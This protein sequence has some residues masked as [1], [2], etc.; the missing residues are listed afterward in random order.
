VP[1]SFFETSNL[2]IVRDNQAEFDILLVKKSEDLFEAIYMKCSHRENPLTATETGLYCS[3]HGSIF[4]LDGNVKKEPAT[5]PLQKFPVDFD[6]TQ[7]LVSINIQSL[8][9]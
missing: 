4:D 7:G 8:K 6:R 1:V 3:A 9:L 5:A 2:A